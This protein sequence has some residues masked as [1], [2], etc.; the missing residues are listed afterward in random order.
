MRNEQLN[1]LLTKNNVNVPAEHTAA[2][3]GASAVGGKRT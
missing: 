2:T 1:E 3:S